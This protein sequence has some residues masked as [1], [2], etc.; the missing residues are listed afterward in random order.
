M[1]PEG[2][3]RDDKWVNVHALTDEMIDQVVELSAPQRSL[4]NAIM[5]KQLNGAAARVSPTATAFP[6][7]QLPYSLLPLAFWLDPAE[8]QANMDWMHEVVAVAAPQA[9]G[10]YVNGADGD[11]LRAIYGVN[12]ERL[13]EVKNRY[14]PTNLFALN[15][16]VRPT[17]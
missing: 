4:G 5:I 2:F 14:D 1:A 6:H 16:N 11:P 7:R 17:L 13:I 15:H 10:V 3:H 12:L 9:G 8:S